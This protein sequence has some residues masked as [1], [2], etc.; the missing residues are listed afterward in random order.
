MTESTSV[1]SEALDMRTSLDRLERRS[2]RQARQIRWMT[3]ALAALPL[4]G[5][6]AGATSQG[7][8]LTAESVEARR[9]VVQSDDGKPR[10]ILQAEAGETSFRLLG[11]DGKPAMVFRISRNQTG[12][13][14]VSLNQFYPTGKPA[15][16]LV[17]TADG[18]ASLALRRPDGK[19]LIALNGKG[20]DSLPEVELGQERRKLE[21]FAGK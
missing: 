10:A 8:N 2:L 15:F 4:I 18:V 11:D 12:Q 6:I 14:V 13:E 17:T 20:T 19:L 5:L 16:G 7:R 1:Q 9:F 21:P 3:L